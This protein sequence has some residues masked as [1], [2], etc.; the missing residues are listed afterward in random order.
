MKNSKRESKFSAEIKTFFENGVKLSD[1]G[2]YAEAI[3]EFN[4]ALEKVPDLAVVIAR[5]ADS[6]LKLG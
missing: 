3:E 5:V 6:Y 1:Q 2:M 4:K